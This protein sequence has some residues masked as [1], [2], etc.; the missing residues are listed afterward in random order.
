VPAD[1]A[2]LDDEGLAAVA[3]V[4][5]A[6]VGGSAARPGEPAAREARFWAAAPAPA[7]VARPVRARASLKAVT[8][9][10]LAPGVSL[11]VEPAGEPG[12]MARA[13]DPHEL[14]RA[15]APL[16]EALRRHGLACEAHEEEETE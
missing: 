5:V 12:R 9:I 6:S 14:A 1:L 16:L 11:I 2:G 15:A 7:R 8:K 13:I 10:E 4:D 3:R